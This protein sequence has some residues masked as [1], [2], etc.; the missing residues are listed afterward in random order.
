[1]TDEQIVAWVDLM[2]EFYYTDPLTEPDPQE[3]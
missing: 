1:M 3:F 2:A